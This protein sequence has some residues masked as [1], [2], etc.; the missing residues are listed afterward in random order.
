MNTRHNRRYILTLLVRFALYF[1]ISAAGVLA[2]IISLGYQKFNIER[3]QFQVQESLRLALAYRALQADLRESAIDIRTIATLDVLV[4]FVRHGTARN[5]ERIQQ[6]FL[7]FAQNALVYDQIRY[8]DAS[9]MERVRVNFDGRVASIV[10][11]DQLQ[12]KSQRYYF[13]DGLRLKPNAIYISPLDLNIEAGQ[14]ERPFKPIIRVATPVYD[15]D[16]R[17]HGIVVLN[18]RAAT[19]LKDFRDFMSDSRG[20][21]MMVNPEGYWLLS[22][23]SED[24]W[25][26]MLGHNETLAKRYPKAWDYMLRHESG[27]VETAEG[28]FIFDTMRPYIVSGVRRL[29]PSKEYV[30]DRYWKIL[31]RVSPQALIY[32]PKSALMSRTGVLAELFLVVGILSVALAWLRTN[33]VTKA[34]ELR[35]SEERFR[36]LVEQASEGIFIASLDGRYTDVNSAGCRMLGYGREEI[37][38]K[39][40][41]DFILPEEEDRLQRSREQL[42]QGGVHVAEWTLRRKDGAYLPVEVSAKILPDGRWQG[43]VRDISK[44]KRTE[45]QLHEYRVQLEE[46]VAQRTAALEASNRDLEAYSYSI[47][48]DLRTPLR[49]IVSFS[50]ILQKDAGP[51]LTEQECRDL[52]RIVKAGKHMTQLIDDI[53][54][55]ARLSRFEIT[56]EEVDLSGLAKI[57]MENLQQAYPQRSVKVNIAPNM[58]CKGDARLLYM[59]LENLL[60]NAWKYTSRCSDARIEFGVMEKD[61]QKNFYVSDNGVGFDMQYA[62]KLFTPFGR[63]HKAGEFEGTGIG[64]ASVQRI[65]ERHNGKVWVE[66]KEGVGTTFYF[67]LPGYQSAP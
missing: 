40:I 19:L 11:P 30:T 14:I 55:F 35:Q 18:Y 6:E 33:N 42:L 66:S 37:V 56:M 36:E 67:T 59:A 17:L 32:S 10:P 38:G 63:L 12:D 45:Q 58:N 60:E 62:D 21:P 50:Q 65:I 39:T 2:A 8:L 15:A 49:S 3:S 34:I 5:R 48:H 25:G 26:F 43:F 61:N 22:P 1:A 28:L 20:E 7:K 54:R 4:D 13:Q 16:G 46:M 53:L 41:L 57:V 64:L 51:K 44:R 47:A 29:A 24:E 27:S 31:T 23:Y 52:Q 9:G